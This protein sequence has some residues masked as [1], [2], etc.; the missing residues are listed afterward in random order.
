MPLDPK[1]NKFTTASGNIVSIDFQDFAANTGNVTLNLATQQID[2]ASGVAETLQYYLTKATPEYSIEASANG[3]GYSYIAN[4]NNRAF[5]ITFNA[6]LTMQGTANF[7]FTVHTPNG[8][9]ADT[10]GTILLK[11][12]ST[13]I[14]TETF[15]IPS[16][17]YLVTKNVAI[18]IPRTS[19]SPDDVFTLDVVASGTSPSPFIYHDPLNRDVGSDDRGGGGFG[20]FSAV[21]ASS[22]TTNSRLIIPVVIQ[23]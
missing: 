9:D 6:A 23:Q 13:T 3:T 10:T 15:R 21:T 19:F 2:G 12:G 14:G 20:T 5:S 4:S 7:I 1:L 8:A 16:N 11:K 17:N 18:S 22:N